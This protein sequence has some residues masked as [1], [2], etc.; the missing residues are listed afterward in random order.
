MLVWEIFLQYHISSQNRQTLTFIISC[1][2]LYLGFQTGWKGFYRK[3]N[4]HPSL[5]L[6]WTQE[7]HLEPTFQM[8]CSRSVCLLI[9]KIFNLGFLPSQFSYVFFFSYSSRGYQISAEMLDLGFW[10]ITHTSKNSFLPE[11]YS[12]VY[13]LSDTIIII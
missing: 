10:W 1:L 5:L 4:Q 9:L 6:L 7:T 2:L 8:P 11:I 3:L 12:K 13:P